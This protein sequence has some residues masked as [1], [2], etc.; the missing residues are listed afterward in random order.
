MRKL[1]ES[2]IPR[3]GV[4]GCIAVRMHSRRCFLSSLGA[5]A[6]APFLPGCRI[7]DDREYLAGVRSRYEREL[8]ESVVPFWEAHSIDREF[9]GFLTCLRRD[10]SIYDTF[11]HLW[12]Q[13]REV[14][15]FARLWNAGYRERRYIDNALHGFDFLLRHGRMADGSYHYL[16][17]RTGKVLSDSDGGMEVFTES[18]AAIGCAELYKAT[19]EERFRREALGAYSVYRRKTAHGS[20][21]YD[22][23]AYPMIELN[24]LSVMREAFGGG[25]DAEIGNAIRRIRRFAEPKT[26]VML[27]RAPKSGGFELETQ[28]GRFVN[29]GHAL[30]GCSFIMRHLRERPDSETLAFVLAEARTMFEFGWDKV[31]GGIWYFR[32]AL[33][34]PMARHEYFLKAWW[35]QNEAASAMLQAYELSG[36]GWYLDAFRRTDEFAWRNLRDAEYGEWFAY[37]PVGGRKFHDYKGSRFKGFFHL[38]RQLLDCI[39]AID[40]IQRSGKAKQMKGTNA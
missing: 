29:P 25:Y 35:P 31:D 40:R 28:F 21:S 33:D 18:F 22:L 19:G 15:M 16:L 6:L 38:P 17:D 12:M 5:A 3:A 14:Y 2:D 30:E 39:Q 7:A 1:A 37:A 32:D 4:D 26:G 36:D 9:G 34:M 27:E 10:G 24:V 11:K 8:L 13:W 20:G 23:L